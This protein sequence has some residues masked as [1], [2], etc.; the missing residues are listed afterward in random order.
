MYNL[1]VVF[2]IP[3]KTVLV[4]NSEVSRRR[5]ACVKNEL[6]RP[7]LQS[8]SFLTH[9][10]SITITPNVPEIYL[11]IVYFCKFCD[12]LSLNI[13]SI[14]LKAHYMYLC[15]NCAQNCC[16]LNAIYTCLRICFCVVYLYYVDM[17]C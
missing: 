16:F 1:T 13:L 12:M 3:D 14:I 11:H 7:L 6:G 10:L 2:F 5:I 9:N 8:D 17:Y 4:L 15:Y